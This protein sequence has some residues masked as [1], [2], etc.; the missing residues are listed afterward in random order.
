M[1]NEEIIAAAQKY[2]EEEKDAR[3]SDEVKALL[4]KRLQGT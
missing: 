4:E 2:I 3:F 1:T